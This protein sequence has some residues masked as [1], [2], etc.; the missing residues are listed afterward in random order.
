MY[1]SFGS[2]VKCELLDKDKIQQ[3]T[4]AVSHLPYKVLWKYENETLPGKPENVLTRKWFPQQAV[5]AHQNV[6]MF[7]TQGGLQ[8]VEEA[9]LNR[10]PMVGISMTGDQHFNIHRLV[11]LGVAESVDFDTFTAE[12]LEISIEKVMHNSR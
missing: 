7:V 8:S 4:Q 10:V 5:L 1:L 3:I 11:K 9:I 12:E 2:S 6:K